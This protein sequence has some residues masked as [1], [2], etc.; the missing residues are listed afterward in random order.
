VLLNVPVQ[1]LAGFLGAQPRHFDVLP[2]AVIFGSVHYYAGFQKAEGPT[3][4][5]NGCLVDAI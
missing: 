2:Q 1:C 5:S 4:I 3:V